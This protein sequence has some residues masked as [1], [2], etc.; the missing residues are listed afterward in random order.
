MEL[1]DF[2]AI[3]QEMR[4]A[5]KEYFNARRHG[6]HTVAGM[7]LGKSKQAEKAVDLALMQMGRPT[8]QPEQAELFTNNAKP[9]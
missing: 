5:Q 3:V 7:W 6:M 2:A 1:K 9:E 4:T 8:A